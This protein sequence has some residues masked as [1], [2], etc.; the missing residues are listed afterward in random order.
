MI[1]VFLPRR[2]QGRAFFWNL[3]LPDS[4]LDN[5]PVPTDPWQQRIRRAEYL[6]SQHSFA[7][8]ILAYY[9]HTARFQQELHRRIA[10]PGSGI[11]LSISQPV[12]LSLVSSFPE[13]LAVVEEKGPKKIGQVARELRQASSETQ[14]SF[15]NACWSYDADR[16]NPEDFL[17]LAFLQPCAEF[18]RSQAG[19]K[20]EGYNH[21]LCPFCSRKATLGTL[22]QQGDG[23][24]RS[25]VCGFCLCEWD[26]RRVLCPACG[27]ENQAKLPVYTAEQFPYVRV[28]CC[29]TCRAYIK[30]IDLTKEGLAVPP[31]DELASI[32]LDLWAQEHDYEKLTPNLLG[33]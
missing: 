30:T 13:F 32:P 33:M 20:L 22:R 23:G 4:R 28:E 17:S 15:L 19:L 9:V 2:T 14:S 10:R 5:R 21:A 3:L 25:L 29:D 7:A 18:A 24:R 1:A 8:E 6:A 12:G 11:D 26:F 16:S 27:E 31:V